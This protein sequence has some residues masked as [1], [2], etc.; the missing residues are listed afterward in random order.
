MKPTELVALG[1]AIGVGGAGVLWGLAQ[2]IP[3]IGVAFGLAIA[4]ATA[5]VVP[6]GIL[7]GWIVPIAA[8][9]VGAAGAAT[10]YVIVVKAVESASE[11]TFRLDT[12]SLSNSGRFP[13][14]SL[15][16]VPPRRPSN[17]NLVCHCG[18]IPNSDGGNSLQ[19]IRAGVEAHRGR[20]SYG[21]TIYHSHVHYR[22]IKKNPNS[23][24][25]LR[26]Y[27]FLRGYQSSVYWSWRL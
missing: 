3:A 14:R 10:A 15:Q 27:R 23:P 2:V 12:P 18:G 13:C 24:L 22:F 11:E 9:G 25:R 7:A 6:V 16:R 20:V 4:L 1:T 19:E 8:A 17:Q 21:A 26:T 5:G